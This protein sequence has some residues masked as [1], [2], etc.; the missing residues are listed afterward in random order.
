MNSECS[1]IFNISNCT[2]KIRKTITKKYAIENNLTNYNDACILSCKQNPHC[3]GS[4][5]FS[6]TFPNGIKKYYC[7]HCLYSDFITNSI[8]NSLNKEFTNLDYTTNKCSDSNCNVSDNI[9]CN[10]SLNKT[11]KKYTIIKKKN[12][13]CFIFNIDKEKFPDYNSFNNACKLKCENIKGC[14]NYFILKS[15]TIKNNKFINLN[16]CVLCNNKDYYKIIDKINNL[17][18]YFNNKCEC[19]NK[20]LK[21]NNECIT[22][23]DN[24]TC[25]GSDEFFVCNQYFTKNGDKCK[26]TSC[27]EN[28]LLDNNS[29]TCLACPNNANCDGSTE[30]TCDQYFIKN[31][32]KC[33]RTSCPINQLLDN[34][35]KTC[36]NCPDNAECDGSTEFTCNKYS[37]KKGDKCKRT[38]CPKNQLFDNNYETCLNCPDN[39]E[40]DGS[41]LFK[42]P[43]YMLK[44][45][46]FFTCDYCPNNAICNGSDTFSCSGNTHL[47]YNECRN[48]PLNATCDN[49]IINCNA[50][51]AKRCTNCY[52]N[53]DNLCIRTNCPNNKLYDNQSKTC[54]DCP[55][56]AICNA[57]DNYICNQYS[58][59]NGDKCVR[60][61]C[62]ENQLFDNKS[63]TCLNCP[64]NYIC[65]GST[66]TKGCSKNSFK[67]ILNNECE[68]CPDNAI[69]NGS[70]D[71]TCN[72]YSTK[73]GDKCERTSCPK[74]QLFDNDSKTCL[75]CPDNARCD[76]SSE[77]SCNKMYIENKQCVNCPENAYC[78]G[79]T[80]T[81]KRY[82]TKNGNMCE[83]TRCRWGYILD[84][85]KKTC[86][87]CPEYGIC[88]GTTNF[89]CERYQGQPLFDELKYR[90]SIDGNIKLKCDRIRC[91]GNQVYKDGKCFQCPTWATC[92]G[93]S[94]W[95][96]PQQYW[97]R[98]DTM[99]CSPCPNGSR[100]NG[101]RWLY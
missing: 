13:K 5:N 9:N 73:Y 101:T 25:N 18:L 67:N 32:D 55:D 69:C 70:D 49:N 48:C 1:N 17:N 50:N 59:K 78:N 66:S 22:C 8:N 29:E 88:D 56:N 11:C 45:N 72:E 2:N 58:I 83:R 20:Y 43:S 93:N 90:S 31:G 28:K 37:I 41:N 87:K 100:C 21:K 65:D 61:S 14:K 23:P 86:I 33:E 51:Y 82:F 27:P 60:T 63:K 71:Y 89:R 97:K 80:F 75:N 30:F 6:Y 36:L 7:F 4:Y 46:E 76:G 74:N 53:N 3:N 42:C 99:T 24:A 44:N 40:C 62:P 10:G 84:D 95:T 26:R 47:Y 94:H 12:N 98:F 81:C 52:Y 68:N 91:P 79:K 38:S 96:C 34:N 35:S 77:F 85:K 15:N 19:S 57:S 92:Y 64:E 39:A 54:L 16:K